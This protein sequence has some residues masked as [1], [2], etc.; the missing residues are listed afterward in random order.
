[1]HLP[2]LRN[3]VYSTIAAIA[4]HPI[5]KNP[6]V[7]YPVTTRTKT[8]KQIKVNRFRAYDGIELIEPGL[9]I[10]VFPAHAEKSD[11]GAVQFKP[12]TLGAQNTEFLYQA[13]YRLIISLAYQEVAIG[14]KT[15]VNYYQNH[16]YFPTEQPHGEQV[17]TEEYKQY[18]RQKDNRPLDKGSVV[19]EINPGE[20]ILRD[21]L[22]IMK[23][24]LDDIRHLPPWNIRSAQIVSYTFPT[25]SWLKQNTDVYFHTA[26][27]T[28]EL[29][30]FPPG[31]LRNL[32]METPKD[33]KIE[34][35]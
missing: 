30:S 35:L 14:E 7:Y 29:V 5:I 17:V 3:I 16:Y 12:Y 2:T 13:T 33:I 26:Y 24:V 11:G 23:I 8:E 32:A 27:I 1:M 34:L 22:D 9:T 31:S 10:S 25:T 28:W 19:V 21:Y 15:R 20:D 18:L 4:S 6:P